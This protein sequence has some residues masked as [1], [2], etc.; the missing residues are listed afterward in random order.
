MNWQPPEEIHI[1]RRISRG[2]IF[3]VLAGSLLAGFA[4]VERDCIFVAVPLYLMAVLAWAMEP[5]SCTLRFDADGI[6]H[7]QSGTRVPYAAITFLCVKGRLLFDAT[8]AAK[9]MEM[10]IGHPGGCLRLP[11]RAPVER[12]ELYRFLRA[13]S[14]LL[15]P[16]AHFPGRL[17]EV[18]EQEVADF[19]AAQVLAS[20]GRGAGPSDVQGVRLFFVVAAIFTVSAIA[21]A[22]GSAHEGIIVTFGMIS[23]FT[24]FIGLLLSAVFRSQRGALRKLRAASGIVISPRGLTLETPALRGALGWAELKG[25]VVMNRGNAIVSGLLL[26]IDGGQILVGDHFTCP[27]TEIQR[28]IEANLA[29]E[30]T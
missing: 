10:L 13:K 7:R 9:E 4:T 25:I 12:L 22:A 28:R 20:G 11:G 2:A 26:K 16:P 1:P 15:D 5:K 18:Y 24:F 19:G 17:R 6:E 8:A 3:F 27:L 23:G 30:R 29:H 21:A 14:R